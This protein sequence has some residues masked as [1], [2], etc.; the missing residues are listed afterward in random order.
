MIRVTSLLVPFAMSVV[1]SVVTAQ[2]SRPATDPLSVTT[3]TFHNTNCPIMGK[4]VS[5]KLYTDTDHGRIYICCKACVKKIDANPEAAYKT[6]Y[7]TTKKLENKLCPV[8]GKPVD[9]KSTVTVQGHEIGLCCA[10]CAKAVRE[11][12]LVVLARL[13]NPK[14]TDVGNKICP[15][16]G[17]PVRANTFVLIGDD[18]VHLSSSSCLDDVKKHPK[19]VLEKAKA[20]K[21][22][23]PKQG[24]QHMHEGSS[25]SQAQ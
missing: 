1:L 16:T 12:S 13:T 4:P 2:G 10:N 22:A 9:G 7:P 8:T 20:E 23:E 17:K 21:S 15:V 11:N 5:T 3:P 19:A 6:A 24:D 14:V 18:L 25:G